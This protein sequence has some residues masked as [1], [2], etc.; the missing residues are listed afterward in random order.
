MDLPTIQ[1]LFSSGCWALDTEFVQGYGTVSP[2]CACAVEIFTG[3]R[4]SVWLAGQRPPCPFP[5]KS[6]LYVVFAGIGEW[7]AFMAEDWPIPRFTLD[8]YV[9]HWNEITGAAPPFGR[10]QHD[11]SLLGAMRFFGLESISVAAKKSARQLI[12]EKYPEYTPAEREEIK[13]Y[14]MDDAL[15]LTRLLPRM[16]SNIEFERAVNRSRYMH[17]AAA[18]EGVG[19]PIDAAAYGKLITHREM[20]MSRWVAE[21]VKDCGFSPYVED[22]K[23]KPHF[24]FESFG[25][26]LRRHDLLRVWQSTPKGRLKTDEEFVERVAKRHPQLRPL[27]DLMKRLR[28]LKNFSLLVNPENS[29]SYFGLNPF[30]SNTTRN[31]PATRSFIFGQSSWKRGLVKPAEGEFVG[32]FDLQAVEFLIQDALSGDTVMQD[33]YLR[34]DDPYIEGAIQFGLA[35]VG[36]TKETHPEIRALMKVWLLSAAYGATRFTL[37]EKL[38][39]E[40][41]ELEATLHDPTLVADDFLRRHRKIYSQ[42]WKWAR[43]NVETFMYQKPYV[44]ETNFGWRLHR[45]PRLPDWRLRN[46]SL[47]FPVQG[48]GSE[49]LRFSATYAIEA[50]VKV[51]A[52]VHDALL[53][54]GPIDREEELVR[55]TKESM[56]RA[57]RNVL[58]GLCAR[59]DAKIFRYP[60]RFME[61]RGEA[62]WNSVMRAL[63]E[64]QGEMGKSATNVATVLATVSCNC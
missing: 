27:A 6:A 35:P 54:V 19:I 60:E 34:S 20:L 58:Y 40:A 23:G 12:L 39:T 59:T 50:C 28:D 18:I 14:C 31:Q 4:I 22:R 57:C 52:T 26:Y 11:K 24:N 25:E 10:K 53:I 42:Y 46:A 3:E 9:E 64:I 37:L 33:A 5:T 55:K 21:F 38:R 29:R 36:A 61:K 17:T 44:L 16:A 56:D 51:A 45:D 49:L 41:P 8:L 62:R 15:A 48:A 43:R 13:V 63:D 32:Y 30:G 1:G 2:V 7:A 47:N